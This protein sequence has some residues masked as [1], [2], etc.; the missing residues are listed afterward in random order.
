MKQP[1]PPPPA[2]PLPDEDGQEADPAPE[3]K[4]MGDEKRQDYAPGDTPPR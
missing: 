1:Q 3:Q 2:P 4:Q